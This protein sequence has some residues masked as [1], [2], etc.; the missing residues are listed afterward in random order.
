M[1]ESKKAVL[2]LTFPDGI[3]LKGLLIKSILRSSASFKAF[4]PLVNNITITESKRTNL[5][6]KSGPIIS[7]AIKIENPLIITF[8]GLINNI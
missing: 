4:A 2:I 6:S 3:G 8:S 1:N 7:D 5:L